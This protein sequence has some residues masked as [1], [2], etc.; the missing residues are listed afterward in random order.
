[1]KKLFKIAFLA[2]VGLTCCFFG[3]CKDDPIEEENPPA[4]EPNKSVTLSDESVSVNVYDSFT[5]Q[6][7]LEGLNGSV[8]WSSSNNSVITVENGKVQAWELGTATI[9]AEL[10]GYKDTC[11]VT[12]HND[13]MRVPTLSLLRLVLILI[14]DT[15]DIAANASP[16]NPS[17]VIL[18]R[19]HCV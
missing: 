16:L 2:T 5:F 19:S 10:N 13:E 6:T 4:N 17:V 7:A 18:P 9:T 8:S 12:V 15:D 3:A 11:M 1:M 14:L